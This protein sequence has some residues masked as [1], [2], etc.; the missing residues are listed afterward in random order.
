MNIL[1]ALIGIGI[2][3]LGRAIYIAKKIKKDPEIKKYGNNPQKAIGIMAITGAVL[4]A[5][6]CIGLP[7]LDALKPTTELKVS[8]NTTSRMTFEEFKTAYNENASEIMN[9]PI[10]EWSIKEG[11]K[12]DTARFDGE[13]YGFLVTM[14]KN[15][16]H[17]V[18]NVIFIFEL[19]QDDTAFMLNNFRMY[20]LVLSI[21]PNTAIDEA[22]QFLLQLAESG[23]KKLTT[24]NNTAY[25]LQNVQGNAVLS[26]TL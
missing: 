13:G 26:I 23:E 24:R 12:A 25:L 11:E 7:V 9:E 8:D 2:A 16:K 14:S 10:T 19:T 18:T 15:S 17:Y 1:L 22:A 5:V 6:G 3:F 20:S 4:F 21:E